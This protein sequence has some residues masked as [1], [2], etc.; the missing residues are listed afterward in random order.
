MR[1][2][3]FIM[4]ISTYLLLMTASC[5]AGSEKPHDHSHEHGTEAHDHSHDHGH[6]GQEAFDAGDTTAIIL[7]DSLQSPEHQSGH[8]HDHEDG[9]RH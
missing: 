9:H 4:V 1:Q 8:N 7:P 2:F 5:N 6:T 3:T